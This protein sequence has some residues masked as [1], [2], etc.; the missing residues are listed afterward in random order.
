MTEPGRRRRSAARLAIVLAI[1]AS[2]CSPASS[3]APPATASASSIPPI[4]TAPTALE[5]P[6]ATSSATLESP[7][8]TAIVPGAVDRSS[9]EVGATYD[10]DLDITVQSGAMAVEAAIEARN[11]SGAPIDR[12]ELNTIAARLGGLRITG[13]TV[14]DQAVTVTIDDQTLRVPLGGILPDGASTTVRLGYTATLGQDLDGS[15]WLFSR[16]GGTLGL[17]R[18]IPWVS[19]AVPSI[20]RTTAT[21]SSHRPALAS[22]SRR[23]RTFR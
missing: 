14:D 9:L 4:A 1:V 12:L 11:D 16:A 6:A 2:A 8:Q 7:L 22:P 18:W 15:N 20:A 21:R 19:R 23:P 3:A 10:V 5:S 13:A 17:Y